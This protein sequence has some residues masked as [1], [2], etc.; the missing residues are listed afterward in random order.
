MII[1]DTVGIPEGCIYSLGEKACASANA[2][3]ES[4]VKALNSAN[5]KSKPLAEGRVYI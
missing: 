3:P 5:S 4:P 1:V 2:N